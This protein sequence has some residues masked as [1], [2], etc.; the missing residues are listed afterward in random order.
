[1]TKTL[2]HTAEERISELIQ[3]IRSLCGSQLFYFASEQ[4]SHQSHMSQC[5]VSVAMC[6]AGELILLLLLLL[7]LLWGPL[8]GCRRSGL[9]RKR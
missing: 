8:V 9:R 6:C 4:N 5:D 7:L 3:V 1:M 2:F